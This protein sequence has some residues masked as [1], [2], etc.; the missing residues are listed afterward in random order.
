M[1]LF[2]I[3]LSISSDKEGMFENDTIWNSAQTKR[4]GEWRK[5]CGGS[6]PVLRKVAVC[7]LSAPTSAG[8]GERNWSTYSLIVSRDLNRL[9]LSVKN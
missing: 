3:F 6:I 1:G 8:A 7:A 2:L 4:P 5:M 9:Q